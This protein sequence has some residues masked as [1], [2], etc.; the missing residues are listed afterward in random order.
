[1]LEEHD[2]ERGEGGLLLGLGETGEALEL[3][4]ELARGSALAGMRA[5][6]AEQDIGGDGEERGEL[7]DERDGELEPAH[8]VVREGLLGDAYMRGHAVG[9]S[10]LQG[11]SHTSPVGLAQ[12]TECDSFAR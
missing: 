8:L 1:M 7:G 5:G 11:Q 10:A 9:I 2:I 3:P 4:L 12:T 6:D